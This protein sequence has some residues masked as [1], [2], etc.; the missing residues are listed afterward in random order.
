MATTDEIL[1]ARQE[2]IDA[3]HRLRPGRSALLIIDMQ[4]G[5]LDPGAALEVPQGREIIPS[6]RRLVEA[7][8]GEDVPVIFTEFVYST[9]VPCLRGDPFGVEHL[10]ARPGEAT[11]FGSPSGNCLIGPGAPPGPDSDAIVPELAPRPDELVILGHTYDKFY[12]T[13][14]DLALRSRD[15]SDL[16]ITG[17]VTDV[18]VNCTVLSAANRNYRVTV[19]TDGVATLWPELQDACFA[20]WR[21][22]FARLRSSDEIIDE[23]RDGRGQLLREPT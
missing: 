7:C 21:R 6:L 23:I 16:I 17:V 5:F 18:C 20:I 13:P 19:V 12:G 10:P 8:R 9:A 14:L 11:G 4:R 2:R 3:L 15:I 1:R 22:K